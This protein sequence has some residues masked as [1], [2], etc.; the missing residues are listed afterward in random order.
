MTKTC[1]RNHPLTPENM[2]YRSDNYWGCR[3]CRKIRKNR[4]I[5]KDPEAHIR[6]TLESMRRAR[7]KHRERMALIRGQVVPDFG[8]GSLKI[9]DARNG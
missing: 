2:Y 5:A 6:R 1:R 9:K 4:Y 3:E 7:K 8:S